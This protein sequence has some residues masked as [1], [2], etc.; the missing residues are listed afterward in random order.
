MTAGRHTP[1]AR[2]QRLLFALFCLAPLVGCSWFGKDEKPPAPLP[3]YRATV[4]ARVLWQQPLESPGHAGFAPVGTPDAVY[5]ATAEG[6]VASFNPATGAPN[7]KAKAGTKLSAGI[8]AGGGML[9]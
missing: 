1:K 9:A 3:D 7:W 2:G 5:V 4:P 6:M 8:G